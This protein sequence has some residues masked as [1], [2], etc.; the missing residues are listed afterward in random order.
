MNILFISSYFLF[1]ETRFG[2]SKR[3]Y[4]IAKELSKKHDLYLL[5]LD[6]CK[7]VGNTPVYPAEFGHFLFVPDDRPRRIYERHLPFN[8]I[9]YLINRHTSKITEFI[10]AASFDAVFLAFPFALSFIDYIGGA[11]RK[12]ITDLEDDLYPEKLRKEAEGVSG[13]LKRRWK[14]YRVKQQLGY[15]E[16]RLRCIKNFVAISQEEVEI[17]HR[18]FPRVNA[19][20]VTYGVDPLEYRFLPPPHDRNTV[21]YIGNYEHI[22]NRDAMSWFL[23]RVHSPLLAKHPAIKFCWAGANIPKTL[24]DEFG[25]DASIVWRENVPD[26]S[27][28]YS[29]ISVFV[30][31]IVSGRGLRTKLIEAAAFGR[32][33]V[34]TGL[35]AEGLEDLTMERADD[36]GAIAAACVKLINNTEYY[37]ETAR[38][39]RKVVDEKYTAAAIGRQ[40]EA[41][42]FS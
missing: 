26:L 8:H 19:R 36:P 10:N 35:G 25:R 31:P 34:S 33:I 21:G 20:I 18:H 30:N 12:N 23:R 37:D 14:Y 7:E 16:K 28:F 1:K 5:C 2:G 15:Y 41:L 32:P 39:N 9:P 40:V 6:G 17:L 22:P 27:D 42:L 11:A 13:P 4:T 38:F 29:Q 24:Q 3:L